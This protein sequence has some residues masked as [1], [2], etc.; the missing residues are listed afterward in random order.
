MRLRFICRLIFSEP[1]PTRLRDVAPV[2]D[3]VTKML[4]WSHRVSRETVPGAQQHVVK[5]HPAAAKTEQPIRLQAAAQRAGGVAERVASP[6]EGGGPR[7]GAAMGNNVLCVYKRPRRGD[8][9]AVG[10]EEDQNITSAQEE[11]L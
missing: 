5:L 3:R 2:S 7:L 6:A 9:E 8:D 4:W 1:P 10:G 11:H